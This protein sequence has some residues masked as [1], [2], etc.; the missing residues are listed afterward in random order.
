[1]YAID[2]GSESESCVTVRAATYPVRFDGQGL[3]CHYHWFPCARDAPDGAE[4][5]SCGEP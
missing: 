5:T 3:P 4:K 2:S 1:M